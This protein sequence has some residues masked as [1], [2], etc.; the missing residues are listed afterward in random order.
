MTTHELLEIV[1]VRGLRLRLQEGRPVV[2]GA[3]EE[4]TGPLLLCLKRHRERIIE[5]LRKQE[6]RP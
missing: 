6:G 1:K 5:T 4:I 2:S 3:K